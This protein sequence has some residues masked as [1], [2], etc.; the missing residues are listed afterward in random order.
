[1]FYSTQDALKQGHAADPARR[2]FFQGLRK[3]F[4]QLTT[5]ALNRNQYNLAAMF[6]CQ[7]QFCREALNSESLMFMVDHIFSD[8]R[9]S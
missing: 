8:Y 5:E 3:V 2:S 9:N 7:S 1:M 6:A 4:K